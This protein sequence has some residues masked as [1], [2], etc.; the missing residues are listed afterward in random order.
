MFFINFVQYFLAQFVSS[1]F[2]K[3][4][5]GINFDNYYIISH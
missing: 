3:T 5:F 2:F 1:V 4:H